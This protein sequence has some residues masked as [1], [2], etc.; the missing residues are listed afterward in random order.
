MHAG[1]R[2]IDAA[3]ANS[4]VP[5]PS[6]TI[7]KDVWAVVSGRTQRVGLRSVPA[8]AQRP[9]YPM[10]SASIDLRASETFVSLP[11]NTSQHGFLFQYFL[12]LFPY[13]T[14]PQHAVNMLVRRSLAARISR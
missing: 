6:R 13:R 10:R 3:T 2:L 4:P 1:W 8:N 5:V 9:L 7:Q 14:G 12:F 11:P